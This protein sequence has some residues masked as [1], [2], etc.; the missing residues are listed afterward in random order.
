MNIDCTL[1]K[2]DTALS[3]ARRPAVMWSGGKDSTVLL[4][5]VRKV[6][7]EIEVIHFKLPFLSHK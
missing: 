2:I 4:H 1:D 5:L 3:R 7:P 6:M